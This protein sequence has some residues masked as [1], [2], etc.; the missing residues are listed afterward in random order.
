MTSDPKNKS[1][2]INKVLPNKILG[3]IYY[4]I[5]KTQSGR[6]RYKSAGRYY[7]KSNAKGFWNKKTSFKHAYLVLKQKKWPLA[8]SLFKTH[9]DKYSDPGAIVPLAFCYISVGEYAKAEIL[10]KK[11]I[12]EN[13]GS[14]DPLSKLALAQK[15]Q[16]KTIDYIRTQR[17][18]LKIKPT[19]NRQ[20]LYAE[21]LASAGMRAEVTVE[22]KKIIT[23]PRKTRS[24]KINATRRIA[25]SFA[26]SFY[27]DKGASVY[28]YTL[29][30]VKSANL[31]N[32]LGLIYEKDNK[33]SSALKTYKNAAKHYPELKW[34]F[35]FKASAMLAAQE[36]Y[37]ISAS[38][39]HEN[40]KTILAAASLTKHKK[41]SVIASIIK[42]DEYYHNK[43]Y[44]ASCKESLK[45][46]SSWL[47]LNIIQ[48]N[49]FNS[50]LTNVI[51]GFFQASPLKVNY[52]LKI[53][54][55]THAENEAL[56]LAARCQRHEKLLMK[57]YMARGIKLAKSKQW[58]SAKPYLKGYH[59]LKL[60]AG[61]PLSQ[62]EYKQLIVCLRETG[63]H[64][65]SLNITAEA[66]KVFP[67]SISLN[68]ELALLHSKNK[69]VYLA[70]KQ[71][72]V[73]QKKWQ[74]RFKPVDYARVAA[75]Y[76]SSYDLEEHDRTISDAIKAYGADNREI[77]YT[78]L[79]S[80]YSKIINANTE[81][82]IFGFGENLKLY[83]A[84]KLL[85]EA[86]EL[87]ARLSNSFLNVEQA[88]KVKRRTV[89]LRLLKAEGFWT[90]GKNQEAVELVKSCLTFIGLNSKTTLF[91]E[92]LS[93]INSART[94]SNSTQEKLVNEISTMKN[95]KLEYIDWLILYDIL[96][97]NKLLVS[98]NA[99]REK[100]LD[101]TLAEPLTGLNVSPYLLHKVLLGFIERRQF[102]NARNILKTME[103]Y[104]PNHPKNSE[105]RVFLEIQSKQSLE[106]SRFYDSPF[107]KSEALNAKLLKN[108]NVAIVGPAPGKNIAKELTDNFDTIIRFNYR[109]NTEEKTDIAYQNGPNL[110]AYL[111]SSIP[112]YMR[113]VSLYN[114]E[115][116]LSE[117]I[118]KDLNS[119]KARFSGSRMQLFNYSMMAVPAVLFDVLHYS[120]KKVKVFN[121]N[122]YLSTTP[123]SKKY[124]EHKGNNKMSNESQVLS[125]RRLH[126]L[127]QA[128]DLISQLR[129]VRNLY[130]N[131]MIEVDQ[132]LLYVLKLS[133]GEYM[134]RMEDIFGFTDYS[135]TIK[136]S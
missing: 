66:L 120:P 27:F 112:K 77:L 110:R 71:W 128:H 50:R 39:F 44:A 61:E 64:L 106:T 3:F 28:L 87:S 52:L 51:L 104:Y 92:V 30:K 33:V 4:A 58:K 130:D 75:A 94:R 17:T 90:S 101:I 127:V 70:A 38:M 108:K 6:R 85:T 37:K 109:A 72:G 49:S 82:Y 8:L 107:K 78:R 118:L 89:I 10:L 114:I 80:T 31:M 46:R 21:A 125:I 133:D 9:Y 62:F 81:K 42:A 19:F 96:S 13:G 15:N 16:K 113:K 111:K 65:S 83:D 68:K 2:F 126:E 26:R 7:K 54:S 93:H 100:A 67:G 60:G 24:A 43:E 103:K 91:I 88:H 36:K 34:W 55:V 102:K 105:V 18:I 1:L 95:S 69:N 53:G 117:A 129:F 123:Y 5:A 74:H 116:I 12:K 122:F 23:N 48:D 98:G 20:V 35:G 86:L 73:I 59:Q 134:N 121:S 40:S 135:S 119:G 132:E 47:N 136:G 25:E 131:T 32:N 14:V 99:A 63:D 56:K 11:F 124:T 22:L 45:A 41:N 76:M 57:T 79:N 97:F 84:E 115:I 29:S